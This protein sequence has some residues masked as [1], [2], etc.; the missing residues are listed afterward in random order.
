MTICMYSGLRIST[1]V[2]LS[3]GVP[4][5]PHTDTPTDARVRIS[6]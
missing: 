2:V 6:N 4:C 5:S 1:R 3:P